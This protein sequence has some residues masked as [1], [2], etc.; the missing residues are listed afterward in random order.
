M[1]HEADYEDGY[2]AGGGDHVVF[3]ARPHHPPY[4]T[5]TH[6]RIDIW[7]FPER[8]EGEIEELRRRVAALEALARYCYDQ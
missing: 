8:A 7:P 6:R 1:R 4:R 3:Q 5:M 2:G